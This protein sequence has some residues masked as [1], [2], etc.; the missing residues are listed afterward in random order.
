MTIFSDV[1]ILNWIK[2]KK[3]L[4]VQ[5]GSFFVISF[6]YNE[7]LVKKGFVRKP[8]VRPGILT[9]IEIAVKLRPPQKIIV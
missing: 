2:Y 3:E 6:F 5:P 7:G 9:C 4:G 8:P 1:T